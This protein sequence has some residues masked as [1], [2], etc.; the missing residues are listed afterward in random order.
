M[1]CKHIFEITFL[2]EPDL[3]F[4]KQLN[5]F[6]YSY[7]TFTIS[8]QSFVSTQ[9]VLFDTLIG[10]YQILQSGPGSNG[11]K[12][13][14]NISPKLQAWILAIR[15]FNIIPRTLVGRDLTPLQRYSRCILHPHPTRLTMEGIELPKQDNIKTYGEKES[16]KYLEILKADIFVQTEIIGQSKKERP[17]RDKTT[18]NQIIQ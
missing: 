3:F 16:Y 11:N 2:N 13:V 9:F 10:P 4:C 15:W 14:L 18:G 8:H 7:I 1:I 12:G 5:G 17:Q 6:M